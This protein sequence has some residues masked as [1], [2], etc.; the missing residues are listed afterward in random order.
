[1]GSVEWALANCD[2]AARRSEAEPEAPEEGV[3]TRSRFWNSLFAYRLSAPG[4][5]LEKPLSSGILVAS[6][7]PTDRMVVGEEDGR[8]KEA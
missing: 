4:G 1:M 7:Q 5:V 6:L 3:S 2:I 8:V